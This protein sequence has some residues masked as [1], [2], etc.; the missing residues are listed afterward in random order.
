DAES[1]G[2]ALQKVERHDPDII[3]VGDMRDSDTVFNA[4]RLVETGC[5][6]I[7]V[8]NAD[9]GSQAINKV[10]EAF[11]DDKQKQGRAQL[12][13][14]LE[15]V[16]AQKLATRVIGGRVAVFEILIVDNKVRETLQESTDLPFSNNGQERAMD[17]ALADLVK[18]GVISSDEAVKKSH[19]AEL[20]RN[21]LQNKKQKTKV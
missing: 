17:Y 19:N 11:P 16:I 4:I 8:L 13:R 3:F 2:I 12:S 9:D 21:I 15:A 20:L 1:F 7:G 18:N 5:L 6:V 14:T 10:L